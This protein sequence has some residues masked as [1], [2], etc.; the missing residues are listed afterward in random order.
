M[1]TLHLKGAFKNNCIQMALGVKA[2]GFKRNI[3]WFL[4][5]YS[6]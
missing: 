3:C 5:R 6:D 2:N 1:K 4:S